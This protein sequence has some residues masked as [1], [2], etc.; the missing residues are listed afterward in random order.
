MLGLIVYAPTM[1]GAVRTRDFV[2][3]LALGIIM[4]GLWAVRMMVRT[5]YRFLFAPFCWVVLAFTGYVVWHYTR[6]D[7]EYAARLE[8]LQ[9][10][11]YAAIFFAVLDNL[12]GQD[13]IQIILFTLVF[14]AMLNAFYAVFQYFTEAQTVLGAPKPEVY[15][16]RGSGTYI[17][18][19]HLAGLLE[20]ALP[21]ALAY[22]ITGR[23]KPLTKVFLAYAA[24]ALLAGIGVT[25]SRGGYIA[26]A[27]A[28]AVLFLSLLWNRDFRLPA[29]GLLVVLVVT[30][31]LFWQRSKPAGMLLLPYLAWSV[32]ALC[33]NFAVWQLN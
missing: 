21:I 6:A 11:L 8:L 19:N 18:P 30:V 29:I 4:M 16:G 14:A 1:F 5:Q 23:L 32:F 3:M 7:I 12:S 33:L 24:V 28:L 27:G 31:V 25:I 20:M 22:T 10:L 17:C 2:V 13:T 26:T 15:K 9:V